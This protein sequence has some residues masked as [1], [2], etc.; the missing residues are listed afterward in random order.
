M[1]NWYQSN[2]PCSWNLIKEKPV[3]F[4][5][6]DL[7][8]QSIYR[9]HRTFW[10]THCPLWQVN[11]ES[12]QATNT[13]TNLQALYIYHNFEG[14]ILE[15][16][17]W[18]CKKILKCYMPTYREWHISGPPNTSANFLIPCPRYQVIFTKSLWL[19]ERNTEAIMFTIQ[20]AHGILM[21][22]S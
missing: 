1:A 15:Y 22:L 20:V 2:H 7:S 19:H 21:I 9:L 8:R 5:S 3:Q 4:S 10:F 17:P 11:W 16:L 18:N 13:V 6:S 12:G 14:N